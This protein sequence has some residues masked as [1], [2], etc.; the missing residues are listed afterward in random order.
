M[1][2]LPG[3]RIFIQHNGVLLKD[4]QVPLTHV[5]SRMHTNAQPNTHKYSISTHTHALAHV[6]TR[7]QHITHSIPSAQTQCMQ[8]TLSLTFALPNKV[9]EDLGPAAVLDVALALT[10]T[11]LRDEYAPPG[12]R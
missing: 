6:F 4:E 8:H 3:D 9:V 10:Q 12:K 11:G 2:H 1:E 7:T 5:H